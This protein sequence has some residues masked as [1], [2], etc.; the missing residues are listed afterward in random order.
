MATFVLT[1]DAGES[2]YPTAEY[3]QDIA[4]TAAGGVATTQWS[5]GARRKGTTT[6]DRVFLLRQTKDRGIVASGRLTDG[7]IFED[8]HWDDPAR[9]ARYAE[10]A[11]DRVLPVEERLPVEELLAA[12][13]GKDWDHVL[14]SGQ[15]LYPPADAQLEAL[16]W[17]HLQALGGAGTAW[18]VS[19]GETLGR[20]ERMERFGGALYGGIE[21]SRSSPNVFV[22]SDP[23]AGTAYGY[24]YDGW[25]ADGSVFFYTGEGRLGDQQLKSGNA[26]ILHHEAEGRA[27][28]LFVADGTEP[29]SATRIQRY[30]GRFR[31]D[32]DEPY[33]IAEAPDAEGNARTVLVFRLLPVGDVLRRDEDYSAAGGAPVRPDAEPVPVRSAATAEGSAEAVPVEA[34]V[35]SSYLVPASTGTTALKREADLLA[36]YQAHLEGRGHRCV[37]YRIRPPGELRDLYT[38]LVDE[39]QNVLYEAKGVATRE[40]VRMALGQLLDYGRHLPTAPAL[41]VLLPARPARDLLDLL[42]RHAVR[43]VYEAAAGRFADA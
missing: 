14:S 36:R 31:V 41:A 30:V 12:V 13:P 17:A 29:G 21:P 33:L 25:S 4:T 23:H 18:T 3:E 22:Y 6:G 26:A 35:T 42:A 15:Q 16:W 20:R 2:G 43:C 40:A 19:V 34:L 11:W 5:F 37:R 28:R 8:E 32:A 38:D 24:H 27:L 7:V 10:V 39:T 1:W 9:T